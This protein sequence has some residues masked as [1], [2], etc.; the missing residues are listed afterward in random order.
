MN[1]WDAYNTLLLS[2]DVDRIRKLTVRTAAFM[3]VYDI[4][5]DI[6]EIGVLKGVGVATWAKLLHIIAPGCNKRV[7]GFDSFDLETFSKNLL[8][9]EEESVKEFQDILGNEPL[10]I[11]KIG[12]NMNTIR[13][14]TGVPIELVVG[15]IEDTAPKYSKKHPGRRISLLHIDVDTYHGT[16]H[17]LLNLWEH[18]TPGGMIL[19]D[20]Y[21]IEGWGESDAVDEFLYGLDNKPDIKTI[22]NSSKPTAY[23]IKA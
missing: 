3:K 18:I 20:E 21:G 14:V 22:S 1:I 13:D 10:D 11:D 17:A 15:D 9:Y 5:G 23:I 16:K 7:I 4:P 2:E 8:D 19:L 12:D 6:V